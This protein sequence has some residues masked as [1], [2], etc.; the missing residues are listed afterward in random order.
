MLCMS[1]A[2][3]RLRAL[4]EARGLSLSELSRRTGIDLAYLSR[5]E[6]GHQR[7]SVAV[8]EDIGRALKADDLLAAVAVI[9]RFRA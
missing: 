6:N 2:G 7:A 9:K 4:R 1:T 8:L 5:V 3:E